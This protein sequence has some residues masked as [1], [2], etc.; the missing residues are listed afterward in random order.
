M[1]DSGFVPENSDNT[2]DI[3]VVQAPQDDAKILETV[4]PHPDATRLK[5]LPVES[6]FVESSFFW[7]AGFGTPLLITLGVAPFLPFNWTACIAVGLLLVA[8]WFTSIARKA[9]KQQ[10]TTW[11]HE[12]IPIYNMWVEPKAARRVLRYVFNPDTGTPDAIDVVV[13]LIMRRDKFY[14]WLR[15]GPLLVGGVILFGAALYG[16]IAGVPYPAYDDKTQSYRR[17]SFSVP[18]WAPLAILLV[19][20]FVLVILWQEWA[21]YY[22]VLADDEIIEAQVRSPFWSWLDDDSESMQLGATIIV[23]G[24][25]PFFAK[26]LGMRWGHLK[27]DSSAQEDLKF[28]SMR[29]IHN[30]DFVVR[31]VRAARRKLNPATANGTP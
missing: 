4:D 27:F 12:A 8:W 2:T 18:L 10:K 24:K 13:K 21:S 9:V 6:D 7:A 31:T 19:V 23:G 26:I 14:L 17:V 30:V 16:S 29:Y 3:P 5:D 25:T 11:A 20:S 28:K 1:S 22:L 15:C